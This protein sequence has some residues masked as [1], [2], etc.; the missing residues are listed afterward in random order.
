MYVNLSGLSVLITGAGTVLGK[1]IALRLAESGANISIQYVRANEE[2]NKL[3]QSLGQIQGYAKDFT[4]AGGAKDLLSSVIRDMGSLDVWVNVPLSPRRSLLS[5]DDRGWSEVFRRTL[6]YYVEGSSMLSKCLI[7]YWREKKISGRI[8]NINS[9]VLPMSD[10]ADYLAFMVAMRAQEALTMYLSRATHSSNI[11]LFTLISPYLRG[12][13]HAYFHSAS[14]S[15]DKEESR[16]GSKSK[17]QDMAPMVIFLCSGLA[18]YASGTTI[19][20][21]ISA[22]D[23]ALS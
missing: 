7:S 23:E 22:Q 15:K 6:M 11:R 17:P 19:D 16:L 20:M 8:I 21:S 10:Q 5:D 1:A 18:D 4:S 9:P 3:L 14:K 12:E 2:T 13:K